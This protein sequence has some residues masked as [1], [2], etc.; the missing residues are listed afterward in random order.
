[1]SLPALTQSQQNAVQQAWRQLL[2]LLPAQI[3]PLAELP[4]LPSPVRQTLALIRHSQLEG[5]KVWPASQ[6]Q[7]QLAAA[8]A[9]SPL[10]APAQATSSSTLAV[11]IQRLTVWERH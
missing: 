9:F 7:P 5:S 3:D 1:M 6:L 2:P 10:Q 8:L 4:E 11:A